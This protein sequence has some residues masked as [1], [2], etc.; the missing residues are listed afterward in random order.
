MGIVLAIVLGVMVLA[1]FYVA[2]MSARTWQIYQVVLVAMIFIGSVVCFYL[3]ARTLATH[4]AWGALVQQRQKELAD[5]EAQ[6]RLALEG[7]RDPAG[8]I[9]K[10]V[11]QLRYDL[12]KLATDRGGVLADVALAG[13]KEGLLKLTLKSADHGLA[14]NSVVFAFDQDTFGEGGRYRGE[15]KVVSVA[16][17]APTV[18]ITPNLPLTEAETQRLSTA[19][20]PWMLYVTMPIDDVAAFASLDEQ[21]RAALLPEGSLGEYSNPERTLRDYESFFHD[22]YVQRALLGDAISKTTS[23]IQRTDAATKQA[24]D[25]IAYRGTE[26]ANLAADLEKF[27]YELKAI[28]AY[29]V[30]L[31]KT[32]QQVRQ[33]LKETYLAS[34]QRAAEL[35][36]AQFK[37]AETINEQSGSG[38]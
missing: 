31:E 2:Y 4:R 27:R 34:K 36:A 12:E 1:S 14:P 33:S 3:G 38:N 30:T 32:F 22:S 9:T 24:N 17:D 5:L 35:T 18:E 11:R 13:F 37:A 29:E 23:N 21:A 8:Q 20:G 28:A 19:K 10:G 16:E 7:G 26:K 6:K 25:E 15:F